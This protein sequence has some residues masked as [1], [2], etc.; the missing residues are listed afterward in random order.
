MTDCPNGDVRDAL[1]DY[2][3]DRLDPARR[4]AVESHLA[5]CATCREELS[6]LR[7]L[8]ATM[9]RA[10]AVYVEAIAAS[11]P[12]YRAPARRS[13]ATS[14]RIAAAIALIAIGGTSVALLR[15]RAGPNP[16]DVTPP[17]AVAPE[18]STDST[19]IA[20]APAS[21]E[22]PVAER[23]SPAPTPERATAVRELALGGGSIADLS[24]HELSA[25][26]D[27]IESL[28]GVPSAEVD[29]PEPVSIP[30]QEGT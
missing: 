1:P 17:V 2:L 26:V 7:T 25:L 6:L 19:P 5:I 4:R 23:V 3:N 16:I 10:P 12:P 24:D 14:G 22:A 29:A 9:R 30:A 13:W 8:R 18:P 11:V 21:V 20:P 15:E 28:D 27:G